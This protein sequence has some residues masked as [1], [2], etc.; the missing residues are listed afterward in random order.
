MIICRF[1][2]VQAVEGHVE[3]IKGN[4]FPLDKNCN[5]N[6]IFNDIQTSSIIIIYKNKN[7]IKS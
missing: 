4:C 5:N 1:A 3:L 7:N 2:K 6:E